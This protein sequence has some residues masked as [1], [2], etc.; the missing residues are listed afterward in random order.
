MGKGRAACR[1]G[2]GEFS[3]SLLLFRTAGSPPPP[4]ARCRH[5]RARAA[6]RPA[7]RR[8]R[9]PWMRRS[10]ALGRA[11]SRL[12]AGPREVCRAGA[13]ALLQQRTPIGVGASPEARRGSRVL[14]HGMSVE[15]GLVVPTRARAYTHTRPSTGETAGWGWGAA[16]LVPVQGTR[17]ASTPGARRRAHTHKTHLFGDW[18]QSQCLKCLGCRPAERLGR[19]RPRDTASR[20]G[21][22]R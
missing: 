21:S 8:A 1:G 3:P 14:G 4:P 15:R 12:R 20:P 7:W 22:G 17:S 9:V 5:P 13:P 10:P 6:G 2:G 18:R 16:V 19:R 11:A